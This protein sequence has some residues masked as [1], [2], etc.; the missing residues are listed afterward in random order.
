MLAFR[1]L[2]LVLVPSFFSAQVSALCH[3]KECNCTNARTGGTASVCIFTKRQKLEMESSDFP[4]ELSS[5]EMSGGKELRF[6]TEVFSKLH[7]LDYVRISFSNVFVRQHTFAN[8]SSTKKVRFE[9]EEGQSLILENSS[10]KNL[11]S[12]I[13]VSITKYD[14]VIIQG[15]AFSW[16]HDLTVKHVSKLEL[17]EDAFFIDRPRGNPDFTI[18]SIV[19]DQVKLD[20]LAAGTFRSLTSDVRLKDSKVQRVRTDA[21]N[22]I[23]LSHV[24]IENTTLN[25]VESGAFSDR[26]ILHTLTL[27]R[28]NLHELEPGAVLSGITNLHIRHSRFGVMNSGALNVTVASASINHNSF[29]RIHSRAFTLKQWNSLSINNNTFRKLDREAF[30]SQGLTKEQPPVINFTRNN[31]YDV[32]SNAFDFE[33][34]DELNPS[35]DSNF[36]HFKCHCDMFKPVKTM[37]KPFPL[38]ETLFQSGLCTIDHLLSKCFD[39]PEGFS[40]MSNYTEEK[41]S[42]DEVILCEEIQR[43]AAIPPLPG[44]I[45]AVDNAFQEDI[46]QERKIFGTIFIIALC[47]MF[48]MMILSAIMWVGRNGYCTK[49]RILLLPSTNSF[50]NYLTRLF[51]GSG[52]TPTGSAHSISR[53]SI[54]EYAELQRKNGEI[55]EEEEI[56][57]EDKATQTLPEELTQEL[58]QSLQEKLNDP[59]NYSEARNMIEH[60]YDLIKVEESCNKNYKDSASINLDDLDKENENLY[61]VIVP[62]RKMSTRGKKEMVSI[63][64]RAP[65]PDKLLPYTVYGETKRIRPAV[66]DYMEPKDRQVHTYT[67]LPNRTSPGQA[68]VVCDYGEPTDTRVHLYTEL[69]ANNRMANRPLPSKPIDGESMS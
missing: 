32:P 40:S 36:F 29:N 27:D 39:L 56:P 21:F 3:R 10:W 57:L 59:E 4:P 9:F 53:L 47:G 55:K 1:A 43:D 45:S 8:M 69:P 12:C 34:N 19:L 37:I 51:S 2:I 41:C 65:S 67:E 35:I 44:I 26:T 63:G 15:K 52:M 33:V 25:R 46:D 23:S 49:A 54:H 6:G 50:I 22:A 42:A 14:Q 48:I 17:L 60:L 30:S 68:S 18:K 11:A 64:T 61:D 58:L 31:L 38:S 16:L 28:V 62:K 66:S 20:N 13:I 7:L 5:V 24:S